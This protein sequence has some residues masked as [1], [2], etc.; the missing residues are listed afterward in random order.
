VCGV[1]RELAVALKSVDPAPT[2]EAPSP[3][4][5][6]RGRR[7]KLS[8]ETY[9]AGLLRH[10]GGAVSSL[11][12]QLCVGCE[13][14]RASPRLLVSGTQGEVVVVEDTVPVKGNASPGGASSAAS[15]FTAPR[16][17]GK[18]G[19]EGLVGDERIW[20]LFARQLLPAARNMVSP[21]PEPTEIPGEQRENLDAHLADLAVVQALQ[22]SFASRR[23]ETVE[24]SP[25]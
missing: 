14:P 10:E 19:S 12:M 24:R 5:K 15:S 23:F 25:A 6:D 21:P 13:R 22:T 7:S 11:A 17:P 9:A 18:A 8:P 20:E 1:K 16:R 4:Q 3:S 2:L